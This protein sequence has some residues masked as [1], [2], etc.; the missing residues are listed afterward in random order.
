MKGKKILQKLCSG[1][2]CATLAFSLSGCFLFEREGYPVSITSIE[3]TA[4]DGLVDT[5]T[6][7]YSD[8]TTSTFTVTNGEDGTDG[9]DGIDGEDGKD[10]VDG[11]GGTV[12]I[13]SI[14]RTSTSGLVDTYTIYYSNDTTSTFEVRNGADGKDVTAMELYETYKVIYNDAGMTYAEF[15]SLYLTDGGEKD[16]SQVINECLLSAAKVFCEFE[17]LDEETS[18]ADDVKPAVY[19]GASVVYQMDETYTYFLTNYHVVHDEDAVG[20]KISQT[21]RCYLYGSEGGPSK[22]T[23]ASGQDYVDYG[24]YAIECEYIGGAVQYDLAII[25][26]DTA[27]VKAINPAVQ[28]VKFAKA[29]HVGQSAITIGNPNSDGLSVTEGIVS[30]DNEFIKLK[31]DGTERSYRSIRMDT[32]L[33]GG[34]SGGGLFNGKGELIGISNAGN[35]TDQNINYAIPLELVKNVAENIMYYYADGNASTSG[36][37]KISL[38][39]TVKG[40]NSKYIYDAMSGYGKIREEVLVSAVSDGGI[41]HALGLQ[42]GDVIKAI[43]IGDTR[44]ELDRYFR[45]GDYTLTLRAGARFAFEYERD[46]SVQ[47]T[48]I[49]TV[50]NTD[51]KSVA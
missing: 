44:Y 46:G 36:V 24:A 38:G 8:G 18:V 7:Y 31:I 50:T 42:A 3:K 28:A 9:K 40:Q 33:Y 37:Y 41:A 17:E 4:T 25:R 45:I 19:T 15:L 30:V 13:V 26:A 20:E 35:T 5:Y 6:I 34:N 39:V 22:K 2:L 23:D 43:V 10:G 32:A 21:I 49:H 27:D 29:Y 12:S 14:R 1:V 11:A 48:P 16:D 51:L 47:T